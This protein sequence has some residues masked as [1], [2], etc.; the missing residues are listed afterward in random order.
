VLELMNELVVQRLAGEVGD[1]LLLVEHE[2]VITGGRGAKLD[3]VLGSPELL[4]AQGIEFY[5]THRGGDVTLHAP[6]QL[7]AYPIVDLKPDRADVRK[8]VQLLTRVMMQLCRPFSIESGVFPGKIGLWADAE[9]AGHFYGPEQA[10]RPV[11]L[12]AVGVRISRWVTSH[13]FALNLTTDLRLFDWIVPCGISEYGVASIEALSG[14]RPTVLG[15]AP[16]AAELIAF[17]LEA[18]LRFFE[19]GQVATAELGAA[20]KH[21]ARAPMSPRSL[22]VESNPGASR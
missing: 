1:V 18:S 2:A 10:S 7:V 17:E 9:D 15:M 8:Y 22:S 3:H 11:K 6:G 13:G 19:L 20:I 21:Q 12:G 16:R 14:E 5:E 4:K